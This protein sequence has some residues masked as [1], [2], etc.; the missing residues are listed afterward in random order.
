VEDD[1]DC[2]GDGNAR[3]DVRVEMIC[4]MLPT[5]LW[6]VYGPDL[7]GRFG[8]LQ[9]TGGLE[10]VI[11]DADGTTTGVIN[12]QFG[13][14]VASV[15]GGT[16]T[17]FTTRV[18]AYGPLPG[19][20]AQ[21]LTDVTQLAASTAWRSRRIDPTGFYWLGARYYEPT[22]GRFLS[23]DPMGQ[24]ASPS[25][26]DFAGGDPVNYFDPTGRCKN[27]ANNVDYKGIGGFFSALQNVE[28]T[29]S[30][31][32]LDGIENSL[33]GA[34]KYGLDLFD[35]LTSL[36]VTGN[37]VDPN[38]NPISPLTTDSRPTVLGFLDQQTL[39]ATGNTATFGLVSGTYNLATGNYQ[40]AQDS[41]ILGLGLLAGVDESPGVGVSTETS[42]PQYIRS[43][44]ND[45][46]NQGGEFIDQGFNSTAGTPTSQIVWPPNRGFVD[47]EGGPATMLPGHLV[48]RYGGPD[49]TF[50]APAGTPPEMRS[51]APGSELRPINTFQVVVPFEVSAGNAAPFFGQPGRGLQFDTAPSTVRDLVNSGALQP[52][53]VQTPTLVTK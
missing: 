48:D 47:G 30:Q 13:N 21:T 26:Y 46:P 32:L 37:A 20:Q 50:L 43:V 14:G 38:W 3:F 12:D 52:V 10:A 34:G 5:F 16:V 31:R 11:L 40:G 42:T 53:P 27:P 36:F 9:G 23:A 6:K 2:F 49:G 22:S 4:C 8:G 41:F 33:V 39:L 19:I 28:E 35:G 15:S 45:F 7:N 29:A 51:L 18:G 24:A 17:W 1:F 25:L 44:G